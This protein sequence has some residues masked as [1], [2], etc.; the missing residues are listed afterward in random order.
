MTSTV[1]ILSAEDLGDIT[2]VSVRVRSEEK[3]SL[4]GE[5]HAYIER[6][7]S[8][9]DTLHRDRITHSH[10][11]FSV[12]EKIRLENPYTQEQLDARIAE[13]R[14]SV[15]ATGYADF[16][17]QPAE[18]QE[19]CFANGGNEK[20]F[21]RLEQ[22]PQEL[23]TQLTTVFPSVDTSTISLLSSAAYH[24]VLEQEVI[25]AFLWE[26]D[27]PDLMEGDTKLVTKA[28]KY[29]LGSGK[30]YDRC[31][32]F[33][34]GTFDFLPSGVSVLSQSFHVN[35]Q[36]GL[37]L[38]D[39]YD[40]YFSGDASVIQAAFNLADLQGSESTYYGV[41][42]VDGTVVRA[43]QYCYDNPSVFSNWDEVI[44]RFAEDHGLS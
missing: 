35:I 29:C 15:D 4:N 41:T 33:S 7:T 31:Y 22:A 11:H 23:I 38:P 43:K 10:N 19:R 42:V 34:N 39:F 18:I 27:V 3:C 36:E 2:V 17:C 37:E 12:I 14:A 40:V 8:F 30:I 13:L 25:T 9:H 24:D 16:E 20:L 26:W 1:E 28:R 5:D 21:Y 44:S 6:G 32:E